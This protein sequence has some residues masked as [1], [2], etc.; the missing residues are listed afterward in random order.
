[1][2]PAL[3][4]EA[5]RRSGLVW[6][7]LDDDPIAHPVWHLWHD[8][9]AYVVTGGAEQPL[10]GADAAVRAV[11][12]VRS[13]ERQGDLLLRWTAQVEQLAPGTPAWDEV[14]PLLHEQRLNAPDGE[15]QP[16][17]WA[18]ESLVLRLVP[19]GGHVPV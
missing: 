5:T 11:V 10:P 9:A 1:V 16:Q 4:E 15:Q 2:E 8:G 7:C 14:V 17:R 6:V 18:R 3:V 13:R 19:D 12:A